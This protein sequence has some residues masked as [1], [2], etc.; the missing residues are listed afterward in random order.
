MGKIH[1]NKLIRDKIPEV[2]NESGGTCKVKKLRTKE[3][4]KEL[5][6]KLGEEADE[7]L[8]ARSTKELIYELADVME[9]I[10]EIQKLKKIT[11]DQ[12]LAAKKDNYGRKGGFEKK[13]FLLWTSDTG[14]VSNERK[15]KHTKK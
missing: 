10:E 15:Y 4:E 8:S 12:I 11:D 3:F 9:V 14:Y 13:L 2:I 7:V 1:Y 6:K 5:L